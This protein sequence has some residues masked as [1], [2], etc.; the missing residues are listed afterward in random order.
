LI[1]RWSDLL[2]FQSSREL[3]A[4]RKGIYMTVKS[5]IYPIATF[6]LAL[7]CAPTSTNSPGD[8]KKQSPKNSGTDKVANPSKNKTPI[9]KLKE[10]YYFTG[11]TGC[12]TGRVVVEAE[13]QE[14]LNRNLCERLQL[15][16]RNEGCAE[17]QRLDYFLH[18]C[19]GQKWNP[20][21]NE[22]VTKE[23]AQGSKFESGTPDEVSKLMLETAKNLK[24]KKINMAEIKNPEIAKY[25]IELAQTIVKNGLNE[26]GPKGIERGVV[27]FAYLKWTD[28]NQIALVATGYAPAASVPEETIDNDPLV[29][30]FVFDEMN[31]T[32]MPLVQVYYEHYTRGF[33]SF[34]EF[35]GHKTSVTELMTIE[36]LKAN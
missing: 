13:T 20:R 14:E 36:T 8:T 7:A 26:T 31:L 6:I 17:S 23:L 28:L 33:R 11:V 5:M 22:L 34:R 25:S 30:A 19:P 35:L 4:R 29:V 16:H 3:I 2:D 10:D 32:K 12:S 18:K 9:K 15:A 21:S 27:T 24:I 1:S